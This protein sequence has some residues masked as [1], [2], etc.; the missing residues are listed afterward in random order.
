[1]NYLDILIALPIGWG[2][3]KGWKRGII[4]EI[5]MMIGLVLGLYVAIKFS[6]LFEGMVKKM[7]DSPEKV[8]PWI[9][10]ILVF[11]L[12]LVVMILLARFLEGILKIG[13]L[14]QIN[15][16]IGAIFGGLKFALTVSVILAIFKPIDSHAKLIDD[17]TKQESLLYH[18]V[19][20]LSHFL[21]PAIEDVKQE[22]E[23]VIPEPKEK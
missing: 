3:Y 21:F 23:K 17:K 16:L 12:V 13:K 1:M 9:T 6:G 8:L 11:V 18:P 2:L 4:F 15:Q 22:F 7:T 19:M 5:A 20:N 14:S 10:F